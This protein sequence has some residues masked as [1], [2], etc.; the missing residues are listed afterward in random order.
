MILGIYNQLI[1]S[2]SSFF[3]DIK[4]NMLFLFLFV[5]SAGTGMLL[6]A[7][8]I[9]SLLES[10]PKAMGFFFIGAVAGGIPIIYKQAQIESF[11]WKYVIYIIIG[12]V[13]VSA[14]SFFPTGTL[15]E[16]ASGE[17][18]SGIFLLL[19]GVIAAAALILPGISV[20]YL[21]LI[22]GLYQELMRAISEFDMTFLF[23]MG[24]GL[25]FGIILLTRGLEFVMHRYPQL[26]YLTILGFVIGSLKEVFPGLPNRS[27]WILCVLA[28]A[29]GFYF[30]YTLS[31]SELA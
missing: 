2:V 4:A 31:K 25:M 10:Y 12:L 28:A 19:A 14:L 15:M 7:K 22:M 20:S 26:S 30:I 27:E 17:N 5:I 16:N 13:V 6:L 8:P 18:Y 9:L 1:E 23:P 11:S 3:K 29:V 21:L 24:V